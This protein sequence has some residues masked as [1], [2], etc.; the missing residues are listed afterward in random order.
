MSGVF[1]EML[2]TLSLSSNYSIVLILFALCGDNW[3]EQVRKAKTHLITY[4]F[5][6]LRWKTLTFIVECVDAVWCNIFYCLPIRAFNFQG[7]QVLPLQIF[8]LQ[9]IVGCLIPHSSPHQ[10]RHYTT[11]SLYSHINFCCYIRE[12]YLICDFIRRSLLFSFFFIFFLKM[13]KQTISK[14]GFSMKQFCQNFKRRSLA[15]CTG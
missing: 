15:C 13:A 5:C 9:L 4:W 8:P 7:L 1:A 11:R 10:F 14:L 2:V 3:S 12:N 6:G